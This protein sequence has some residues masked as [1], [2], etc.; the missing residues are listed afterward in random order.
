M[1]I[2]I[3][4]LA[5]VCVLGEK[6]EYGTEHCQNVLAVDCSTYPDEPVCVHDG[7]TYKTIM[8]SCLFAHEICSHHGHSMHAV[9]D[10]HCFATTPAP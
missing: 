6:P 9:H 10:G 1:K 3:L 4:A 8:N 7:S 2:F 5:F